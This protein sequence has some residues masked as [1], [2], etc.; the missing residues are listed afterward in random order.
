MA[1]GECPPDFFCSHWWGESIV[2]FVACVA[3]HCK[4]RGLQSK[5]GY[6]YGNKMGDD[7]SMSTTMDPHPGYLGGRSPLY[8]CVLSS[9]A[10][11]DRAVCARICAYANRQFDLASEISGDSLEATSFFRAIKIAKGTVVI[12]DRNGTVYT[13]IWV[14]PLLCNRCVG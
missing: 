5:V 4:D 13:R 2:Q 9:G 14:R 10:A 3:R 12:V 8:W 6:L 1:D 11:A 7:H